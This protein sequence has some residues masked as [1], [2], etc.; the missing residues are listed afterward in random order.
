MEPWVWKAEA[1]LVPS[2]MACPRIGH[3]QQPLPRPVAR[4]R[5][6]PRSRCRGARHSASHSGASYSCAPGPSGST[7]CSAHWPAG[8]GGTLGNRTDSE[9]L[10]D[11]RFADVSETVFRND[12]SKPHSLPDQDDRAAQHRASVDTDEQVGRRGRLGANLDEM[13][14]IPRPLPQKRQ[15]LGYDMKR[16]FHTLVLPT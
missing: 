10:A 5:T 7:A 14:R 13:K 12:S 8:G 11:S 3:A 1:L 4:P 16:S 6:V 2:Q 15:V 9:D